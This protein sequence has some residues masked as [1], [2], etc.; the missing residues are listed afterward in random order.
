MLLCAKERCPPLLS[1][2]GVFRGRPWDARGKS[3][4]SRFQQFDLEF[5]AQREGN[6]L[7]EFVLL[8]LV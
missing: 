7:D 5:D 1:L 8:V 2:R 6:A 3:I 4:N